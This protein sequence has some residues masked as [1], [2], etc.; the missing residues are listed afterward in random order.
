ML[1]IDIKEIACLEIY[2][3]LFVQKLSV[4]EVEI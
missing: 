2:S 3:I 4:K 1:P